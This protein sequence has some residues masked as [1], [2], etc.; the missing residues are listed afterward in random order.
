[1]T[2]TLNEWKDYLNTEK[3]LKD[4]WTRFIQKKENEEAIFEVLTAHQ[5]N[6]FIKQKVYN[7]DTMC[8]EQ[9]NRFEDRKMKW[10]YVQIREIRGWKNLK[11]STINKMIALIQ[12]IQTCQKALN[13]NRP[14]F[15]PW[16]SEN[17]PVKYWPNSQRDFTSPTKEK[18]STTPL[19][20]EEAEEKRKKDLD[21]L[22][23]YDP[24]EPRWNR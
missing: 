21:D 4:S 13:T 23:S 14:A 22:Y 8:Y 7:A 24:D 17:Y 6:N 3:L 9:T 11:Q 2:L 10:A 16:S 12:A 15:H 20:E 19:S 5:Y 1:M 18:N